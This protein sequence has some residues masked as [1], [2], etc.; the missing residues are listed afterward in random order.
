MKNSFQHVCVGLSLAL[1]LSG[2][3]ACSHDKKQE[4]ASE[5]GPSEP[6]SDVDTAT[7]RTT[8]EGRVAA[9]KTTDAVADSLQR[10]AAATTST[11]DDSTA[12]GSVDSMAAVNAQADN[13]GVNRLHDGVTG[14]SADQQG[15]SKSDVETTRRIR[16][17]L[18]VNKDLSTYAHNVKIITNNG[19][20][21]LKGPV[22]S[23]A[24][25]QV[26]E[27]AAVQVAGA[28]NVTSGLEIKSKQAGR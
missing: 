16:R 20:V 4:T 24:E 7:A 11:T 9:H 23:D 15:N 5:V 25:R 26:V 22:R 1:A 17:L 28:S 10:P 12:S 8:R 14:I 3:M 18:T 27:D 13:S 19:H 2:T 21:T 6:A